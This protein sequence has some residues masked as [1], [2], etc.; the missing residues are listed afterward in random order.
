MADVARPAHLGDVDQALDARLELHEGAVVGDR[1]HLALHPR[2][3]RILL[4]HVLPRVRL[5]LLHAERDPLAL[6]VDVENLDLDFLADRHQ[7]AGVRHP[8]VRHVG[9]VQ[10]SVDAAEVDE[11]AEIGDVLDDPVAHLADFE[12]LHQVLALVGA[13]VLEDHPA[14]DDDVAA[15]LVELDDLELVGLAQQL[16]DVGHPAQR[17]LRPGQEGVDAHQVH[18][19][20]A[21]DLLHQSAFDRLVALVRLADLLPDA[22][23]I[24][25]LLRQDHRP[26]LVFEVLEEDL[27]LVADLEI[28]GILEFIER[29]RPFRLEPDVEDDGVVGDPEDLRLDDLAFDDLRHRALVEGEHVL[30]FRVGVFLVV[31]VRPD[32]EAVRRFERGAGG[33]VVRG[34]GVRIC[35]VGYLPEAAPAARGLRV[36]TGMP[37]PTGFGQAMKDIGRL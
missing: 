1:D 7:L 17:D 4:G 27:D 35:H 21:L 32:A 24:G 11:R 16:V 3:D 20:A 22:H 29:N 5:Q 18:H 2:A 23:E 28:L 19:H 37:R 26:F 33:R 8:A 12:L 31:E 13:L 14:R 25:L 30:V 15:P 6:P 10:Q 9:D 34:G 36:N